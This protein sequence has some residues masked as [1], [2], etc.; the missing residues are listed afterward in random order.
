MLYFAAVSNTKYV[1]YVVAALDMMHSQQVSLAARK[2]DV[3][4]TE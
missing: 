4:V 2:E 3:E 1:R